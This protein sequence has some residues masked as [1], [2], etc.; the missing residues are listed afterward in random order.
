MR[1][2]SRMPDVV[3]ARAADRYVLNAGV[4]KNRESA[5]R[6]IHQLLA[7]TGVS[8]RH[9]KEQLTIG[10][11]KWTEAEGIGAHRKFNT[12]Y[13]SEAVMAQQSAKINHEH[14]WT[15]DNHVRALRAQSCHSATSRTTCGYSGSR[16][17]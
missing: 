1:R 6:L 7:L 13:F 11:W 16:A 3:V 4:E 17:S 15:I 8:P 12:R 10:L 2:G 14:V 9:V 5:L